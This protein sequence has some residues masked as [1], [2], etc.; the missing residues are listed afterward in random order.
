MSTPPEIDTQQQHAIRHWRPEDSWYKP[1]LC[2][3]VVQ[4]SRFVMRGMNRLSFRD[5]GRWEAAFAD[6]SGV[7]VLSFS[8]HVSL[9]DDPL[10]VSN[11]GATRYAEVRWIPAD[12][13]NFFSSRLMGMVFSS[14]KCV[15]IIRGGGPVSYTHLTL[16]TNSLV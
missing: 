14:G 12:H 15:P 9:F 3:L 2:G 7:G 10:L 5:Q 4:L 11:L 1:L 16:P 6:S 13:K 8:N